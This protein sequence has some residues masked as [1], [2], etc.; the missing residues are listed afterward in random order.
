[1]K[2][3]D[4]EKFLEKLEIAFIFADKEMNLVYANRYAIKKLFHGKLKL[5]YGKDIRIFHSESAKTKIKQIYKKA[6]KIRYGNFPLIKL[7]N[8]KDKT[9]M[10]LVKIDKLIDK[11]NEFGGFV[12]SFFDI[13]SIT[14]NHITQKMERILAIGKRHRI[15]LVD[16]NRIIYIRADKGGSLIKDT[17]N[18]LY[19]SNLPLNKL[20][21]RLS[22]DGFLRIHRYCIVSLKYIKSIK[23]VRDN[24]FAAELTSNHDVLP[25]SR[26]Q[27][28]KLKN[29]FSI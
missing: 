21:H 2:E 10:Y 7:I 25:V 28:Y 27:Y 11:E 14:I 16:V 20:E 13:S 1:M 18:N 29:I 8:E 26:R 12:L 24:T 15:M 23:K 5:F 4:L 9:I 3:K 22:S 6:D 17:E 19:K